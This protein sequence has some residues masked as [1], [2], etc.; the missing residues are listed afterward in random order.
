MKKLAFAPAYLV[1]IC[2]VCIFSVSHS[3]EANNELKP[4]FNSTDLIHT[5]PNLK[6]IIYDVAKGLTINDFQKELKQLDIFDKKSPYVKS[7]N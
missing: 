5:N 6:T 7:D 2:A 3:V 1:L 4:T